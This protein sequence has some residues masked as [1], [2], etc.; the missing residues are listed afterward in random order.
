MIPWA[1]PDIGGRE[2]EYVMQALRSTWISG[3]KFVDEFEKSLSH[4]FHGKSVLACSNGTSA[5]QLA[6]QVLGLQPGDELVIP[7]FGYMAAA[8]VARQMG[9]VPVF[10]DIREDTWCLDTE[11]VA[12][13]FS[14]R[15]RAVVAIHTYGSA[16]EM[17]SLVQ[18]SEAAGI[19]VIEDCA[20][21]FGS[22]LDN[23]WL[24]TFGT[25][26]TLSFQATKTISTGEGGAFISSHPELLKLGALYR[27]HGVEAKRYWHV[28]PGNN[29]RLTNLQAAIGCAQ[30]EQFESFAQSRR[31]IAAKYR[32]LLGDDS[33]LSLQAAP[34][35]MK[36]VPWTF[37]VR[38]L[39]VDAERRDAVMHKLASAGIETR[40]GFYTPNEMPGYGIHR[41]PR[42]EQVSQ[43]MIVLPFYPSMTNSDLE[44][45]CSELLKNVQ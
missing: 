5:I 29:Y 36:A 22:I 15:T 18:V 2:E 37:G 24:G 13:H 30:L 40:P 7:G 34:P 10:A 23:Q 3:G 11:T 43:E 35:K 17:R 28:I 14:S 31:R 9:V 20:E 12:D 19:P 16:C 8:N 39:G 26:G 38:L 27:S 33:R 32:S 6:Y 1:K 21:S 4:L 44:R 45:V 42:S 41:I 25:I